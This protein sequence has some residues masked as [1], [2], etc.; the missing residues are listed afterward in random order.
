[1]TMAGGTSPPGTETP[2]AASVEQ[3]RAR[4][5]AAVP[6]LPAEGVP[7]AEA[8]GRVLAVDIVAPRDLWPFPRAAMDGYALR[9]RDVAAAS[10]AHPVK[11]RVNGASFAGSVGAPRV[12]AGTAVR[13]ATGAPVPEGADAV[14]PFEDVEVQADTVWVRSPVPA[15]RHIFPA[16]ED[17]R[18]GEVVL[19]AGT[20]L[21]GGHLGLLASL[22]AVTVEVVRRA[23]VAILAVGDELVEAGSAL[24]PGQVVE[25]NSYM[26]AAE[27]TSVG[28][29]P[30]RLGIARDDLD[31]LTSRIHTGLQ[32]D[33]LVVTAGMSVGER[34]LVKEAMRRTGVDLLFWR[35][36]MKPGR[37]AAFGLAGRTAVFGLPGTPGAAMVTFEE[38]VRPALRAMMGGAP[39]RS[40]LP[41]RLEAPLRVR[42]GRSRY[43]WARAAASAGGLRVTP[44][45]GQG[46]ATLRSISDANALIL[47]PPEAAELRRGDAVRVQLL[48]EPEARAEPAGVPMVAVVGAKGAG[49]T[50]LIE[51]LLPELRRR[52][53]RVAAIKH[54]VHG[55]EIDREGTDTWRFARAGA[56][57]VAIAGPGKV[58]VVR[59][60][61]GEASLQQVEE[62]VG[63][64]DLI[65]LEG[66]SREPV[67]KIEVRRTA[68][69][70]DRPAPAG[71]I[72]AVVAD[73]PGDGS[74]TFGEIPA[75]ADLIER[76]LEAGP[77]GSAATRPSS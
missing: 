36:P 24:R 44:L 5:L 63:A 70:S 56:D 27:V 15:G 1:M 29:I 34:D 30:L 6:R 76:T 13:V 59:A 35:V 75:L 31:D 77:R 52:G 16:G 53:Y 67:P 60:T 48:A 26:L 28:G 68:V 23:R 65:L 25:S 62:M 10:A 20:A 47:I 49:K 12:E 7:L 33:V 66:Y 9:A 54:D 18:R 40:W 43:L 19:T 3:A 8:A 39:P 32:A 73:V 57:A 50:F 2:P 11:L 41:A 46:T 4:I 17:A 58:A 51:R 14:V 64:A 74:L 71:P 22:G 55:F 38:L 45:R 72:L 69:Q 61:D 37:P 21:R 42:P